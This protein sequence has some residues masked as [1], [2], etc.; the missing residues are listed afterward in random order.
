M[1]F[2]NSFL[3]K[4][5]R[6]PLV[7]DQQGIFLAE[8]SLSKSLVAV[9]TLRSLVT[10]MKAVAM[11]CRDYASHTHMSYRNNEN[12]PP[13]FDGHL[14][15]ALPEQKATHEGSGSRSESNLTHQ[16]HCVSRHGKGHRRNK[17]SPQKLPKSVPPKH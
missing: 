7:F 4:D 16:N 10:L 3:H 12:P 6:K 13:D 14:E 15:K 1:F 17:R 5:P 8:S 11:L 9:T 2:Y